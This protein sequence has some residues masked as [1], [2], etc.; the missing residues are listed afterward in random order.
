[1]V[2]LLIIEIN[3]EFKTLNTSAKSFILSYGN[4]ILGVVASEQY[5]YTYIYIYFFSFS[6]PRSLDIYTLD[7]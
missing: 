5:I 7:L 2:A 3:T 6:L 4:V 1:M